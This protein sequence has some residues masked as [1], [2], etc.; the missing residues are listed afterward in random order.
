MAAPTATESQPAPPAQAPP[1]H[2][3]YVP[4]HVKMPEFTI[5]AVILGTSL[6]LIFAASSLYLVLKIGMTVSASIPVAV[7]AITLFRGR[8]THN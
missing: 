8:S 6:G 1:Q 4:D 7:L 3:P 5:S 2:K